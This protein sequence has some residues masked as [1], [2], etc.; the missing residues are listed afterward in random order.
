MNKKEAQIVLGKI[1]ADYRKKTHRE[2]LYLIKTQDT[3]EVV[4]ESDTRYQIEIQAFWDDEKKKNFRVIGSIDDG[5]IRAF[6]PMTDD[7]IITRDG[8]FIV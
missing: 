5:G 1:L 2:L 3:F 7:F 6:F 4:A 8:D